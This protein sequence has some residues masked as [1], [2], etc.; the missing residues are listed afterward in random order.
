ML[1][2]RVIEIAH[3]II[4]TSR[5]NTR[6][7]ISKE[8]WWPGINHDVVDSDT[9]NTRYLTKEI[10]HGRVHMDHYMINDVELILL[11]SDASSN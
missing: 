7:L 4:H 1:R 3:D 5:E 9:E 6:A 11:L 2:R 10:V 8:L